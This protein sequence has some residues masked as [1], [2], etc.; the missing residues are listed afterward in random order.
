MYR[1]PRQ[2]PLGSPAHKQRPFSPLSTGQGLSGLTPRTCVHFLHYSP[3][4][5]RTPRA[6]T[7]E[8][9]SGPMWIS[10]WVLCRGW[11][12]VLST[13]IQARGDPLEGSDHVKSGWSSQG[14][15]AV[16]SKVGSPGWEPELRRSLVCC[17]VCERRLTSIFLFKFPS[18]S[19]PP[20]PQPPTWV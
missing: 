11:T 7:A 15:E 14:T 5:F 9:D 8:P 13:H 16:G 3:Q 17:W 6:S 20:A 4:M 18:S 1:G 12:V 2:W 19:G 10:P